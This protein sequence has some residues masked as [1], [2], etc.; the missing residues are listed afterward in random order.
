MLEEPVPGTE[1]AMRCLWCAR[2]PPTPPIGSVC[3]MC[4]ALRPR[5]AQRKFRQRSLKQLRLFASCLKLL[6]SIPT[7]ANHEQAS[8][9]PASFEHCLARPNNIWHPSRRRLSHSA[10]VTANCSH[11]FEHVGRRAVRCLRHQHIFFHIQTDKI[12]FQSA[13]TC[14]SSH[15]LQAFY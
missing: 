15:T 14:R 12:S 11:K 10:R 5:D 8:L 2:P 13:S 4:G 6:A 1:T 9:Q 7:R 3:I